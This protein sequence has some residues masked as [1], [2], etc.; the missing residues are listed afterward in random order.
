MFKVPAY[1]F[2]ISFS[3]TSS[4]FSPLV[5]CYIKP[6]LHYLLFEKLKILYMVSVVAEFYGIMAEVFNDSLYYCCMKS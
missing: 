2:I 5:F 3:P 4:I 1:L 6:K